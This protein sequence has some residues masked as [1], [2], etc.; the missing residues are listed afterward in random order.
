LSG[1]T[2][3]E[4]AESERLLQLE[5]ELHKTVVSQDDAV[6]AVSRAIRKAR[7]GLKDPKRPMGCFIFVGPSGVGKTLLAKA[8]AEFMFGDPDAMIYLDMSEYM[9]KHNVSRLVGAPPGYVGYEEGGQLTERIR[10]R[11]YAVVLLDE[12]EKAHPDVFNMLLQIMEEGRLTD[13]FGRHVDFKNVILIMTSNLGADVIKGGSAFGFGKRTEVIDYERMR[14]ALMGEI[15]KFFRPEFI[16]RLDEVVVFRPLLKD[17]LVTI[18]EYELSKVRKR[19]A[20]KGMK[21]ELDGL[22]KDFLIEKGYNPDFGARPLRRALGQY[23]EDPLAEN[24]LMGEF[25]SGDEI[26]VTREEGKDHLTF[27]AVRSGGGDGGGGGGGDG[28][29]PDQPTTPPLAGATS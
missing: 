6:K 2:R 11:P 14:K 5:A 15:E 4:K 8:L 9:E 17:D 25:K 27:K 19:L 16:N 29:S 13:S 1:L 20:E 3:L 22:A 12:V 21:M 10:R 23:I 7:S 26:H 28:G 24:L 18:I